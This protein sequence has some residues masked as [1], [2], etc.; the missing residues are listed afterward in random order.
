MSSSSPAELIPITPR[1]H[2]GSKRRAD[3]YQLE[4]FAHAREADLIGGHP[5]TCLLEGALAFLDSFPALL[6]RGEIPSFATTANH[7]EAPLG[8]VEGKAP[9]HREVLDHLVRAER[10]LAEKAGGV[11]AAISGGG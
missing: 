4:S 7:P 8:A 11:H 9:T 3:P 5:Q 6:E 2:L 10:S 1:R